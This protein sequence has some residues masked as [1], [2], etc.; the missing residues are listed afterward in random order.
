MYL[1]APSGLDLPRERRRLALAMTGARY[2]GAWD[3]EAAATYD[4]FD[5]KGR[6]ELMLQDLHLSEFSFAPVQA[7]P[8]LHPGKAAA[9]KIRG[10][11]VG[12]LGELHPVTKQRYDFGQDA[13]LVAEIDLELLSQM[14]PS[15]E[16]RPVPE[17]PPVLEDIAII[18]DESVPVS[19]VEALIREAGG[20]SLARVRLFDVYRGEQIPTGKK[21]LAYG[22]TYQAAD[23]TLTD[24]EAAAIRREVVK[25]L[26]QDLGATLRS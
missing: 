25:R 2:A 20:A 18:L 4:F 19:R 1:L 15:F 6:L 23:R 9:V 22:L 16:F 10:Q 11:T 21:S 17:F 14:A 7:V 26:E 8:W 5:L 12:T 3:K 24:A 13:V